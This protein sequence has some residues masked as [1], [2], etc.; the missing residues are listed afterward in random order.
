MQGVC[1]WIMRIDFLG[2][3]ADQSRQQDNDDTSPVE[4][5]PFF[6][7]QDSAAWASFS[8]NVAT[9]YQSLSNVPVGT[10]KDFFFHISRCLGYK[11]PSTGKEPLRHPYWFD[12]ARFRPEGESCCGSDIRDV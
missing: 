5:Q 6:E 1:A 4:S 7:D 3:W 11:T 8:S 12:E 2:K 10:F 9:A